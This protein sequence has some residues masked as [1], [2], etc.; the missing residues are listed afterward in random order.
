[1]IAITT[2]FQ[3]RQ[4]FASRSLSANNLYLI[5]MNKLHSTIF[6]LTPL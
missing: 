5:G 3:C 4:L 1:M 2:S 6:D